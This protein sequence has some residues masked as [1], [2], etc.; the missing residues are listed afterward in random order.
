M[1][2]QGH[3]SELSVS[4]KK[5]LPRRVVDLRAAANC[6]PELRWRPVASSMSG[7][8]VPLDE[9]LEHLAE[10]LST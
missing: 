1:N 4:A 5:P 9:V 6:P 2:G 3:G 10:G 8:I 7:D